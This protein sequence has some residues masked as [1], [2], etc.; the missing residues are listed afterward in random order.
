MSLDMYSTR[1]KSA[2]TFMQ[3]GQRFEPHAVCTTLQSLYNMVRYNMVSDTTWFKGGPQKSI[4]YIEQ[5]KCLMALWTGFSV[6]FWNR[7]LTLAETKEFF[8]TDQSDHIFLKKLLHT[9]LM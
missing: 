4:D 6:Q 1:Q 2:H 8:S 7:L 5:V 3:C 9:Q